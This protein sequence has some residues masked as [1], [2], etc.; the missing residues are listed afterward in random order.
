MVG[1]TTETVEGASLS[2]ESVDNVERGD[3]LSLGVLGVCDGVTDDTLEESL[4]NTAGLF[5]DHCRREIKLACCL[6][7][8]CGAGL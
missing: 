3:R 5:V 1:L 4:E 2:L 7:R 6:H 8:V